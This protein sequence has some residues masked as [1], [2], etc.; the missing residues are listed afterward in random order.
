[1]YHS[2]VIARAAQFSVER[3]KPYCFPTHYTVY[4]NSTPHATRPCDFT[5]SSVVIRLSLK[6]SFLEK[7]GE[8]GS[9]YV[10]SNKRYRC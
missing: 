6:L 7:L 2:S 9:Y 8:L 5:A 4:I 1:M 3:F 10:A